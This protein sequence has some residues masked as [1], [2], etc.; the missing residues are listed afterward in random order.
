MAYKSFISICNRTNKQIT[1]HVE[2]WGKQIPMP[3]DSS[4][5]VVAEA[6]EPGELEIQY[7]END[8]LVWGWTGSI[9]TIFANG[10]ETGSKRAEVPTTPR[11]GGRR[12]S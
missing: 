3:A 1:L 9:L 11:Q 10:R 2:P 6:R 7:E 8:I 12:L 5:Q 4:F